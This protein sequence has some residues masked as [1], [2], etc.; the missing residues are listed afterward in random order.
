ML[1]STRE[2]ACA[3]DD[4][5]T[6]LAENASSSAELAWQTPAD[7]SCS[8]REQIESRVAALTSQRLAP[9]EAK[10]RLPRIQ[11]ELQREDSTWRA[12]VRA[13]DAG[14]RALGARELL[15][16]SPDCR[17]LDVALA[18]VIATLVDA[19]PAAA[20]ATSSPGAAAAESGVVAVAAGGGRRGEG[21][22]VAFG[23]RLGAGLIPN[24]V[25]G[26]NL[27]V[28]IPVLG[29]SIVID[30]TAYLPDDDVDARGRGARLWPWHAGVGFCPRL[31]RG[32][33]GFQVCGQVQLG[34]IHARGLGLD[35]SSMRQR[36]LV[37]AGL[38]PKLGLSLADGF[39]LQLSALGGWAP[40]RPEFTLDL[41]SSDLDTLRGAPFVLLLR[42]GIIGFFR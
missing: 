24:L 39:G 23:A 2:V 8:T 41:G 7:S 1:M 18:L 28:E 19:L 40:V 10:Q 32:T 11:V 9:A 20:P 13:F 42:I 15:G 22:G 36:L 34:A 35:S 27:G 31:V 25:F 6:A 3:F 29:A 37:I 4:P 38:E 21:V 14:G 33:I 26:L 17:S 16:K 30:G 12:Q 5:P